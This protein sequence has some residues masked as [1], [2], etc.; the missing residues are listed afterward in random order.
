MIAPLTLACLWAV[1]ASLSP[2]LP[3]RYHGAATV[4]LIVAGIPLAG[5]VTYQNGPLWGMLTLAAGAVI[6]RWPVIPLLRK[7]LRR[8]EGQ[9]PAE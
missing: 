1:A 7:L 2:L 8:T 3:R 5:W 4:A 6:L 9:E